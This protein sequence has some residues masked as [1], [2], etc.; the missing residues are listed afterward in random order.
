VWRIKTQYGRELVRTGNHPLLTIDGWKSVE[1]L[2]VGEKLAMPTSL[3]IEGARPMD[4]DE[5]KVL[6]YLIGDGNLGGPSVAFTQQEGP[7]LDEFRTCI[8]RMGCRLVKTNGDQYTYRIVRAE[9]A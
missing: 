4:E 8:E 9:D 5:L 3:P 1:A 2:S 6:A 7:Q